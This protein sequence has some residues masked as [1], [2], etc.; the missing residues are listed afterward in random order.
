MII[1]KVWKMV[2]HRIMDDGSWITDQNHIKRV[3][4][5]FFITKLHN[6]E[7]IRTIQRNH[8]FKRL[9]TNQLLD[10]GFNLDKV[11]NMVRINVVRS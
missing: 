9:S 8:K 2:I 6:Y 5:D 4:H 10:S 7:G 11:V 3:F 1:R